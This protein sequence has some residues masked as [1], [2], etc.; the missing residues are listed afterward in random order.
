MALKVM[1]SAASR[2]R[3]VMKDVN[4]LTASNAQQPVA[5]AEVAVPLQ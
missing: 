3:D 1:L 2:V 5:A 4:A